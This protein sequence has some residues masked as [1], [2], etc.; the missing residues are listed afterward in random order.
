MLLN[1]L[2]RRVLP[3]TLAKLAE[4]Q[5]SCGRLLVLGGGVV[6]LFALTAL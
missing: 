1:F 4:F 5:P 6:A 3:A 2:V